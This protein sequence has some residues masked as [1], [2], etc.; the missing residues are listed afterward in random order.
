VV[1]HGA[2]KPVLATFVTAAPPPVS[3]THV[4]TYA[5]PESAIAA[6]AHV[7]R[8]AEWRRQPLEATVHFPDFDR[9]AARRVADDVLARGGGWLTPEETQSLLTAAGIPM[10]R[11]RTVS[12]IDDVVDAAR[13]IGLPVALKAVGPAIVHKSDVGGVR[14]ALATEAD[15]RAAALDM[16]ARLG[17]SLTGF[18]VQQMAPPGVEM[19]AGAIT[20]PQFGPVLSC[21]VGGVLV[22]IAA[23]MAFRLHPLSQRDARE[24][25]NEL[26]GARLL[27]GFRGAP[28]A[29]EPALDDVLL[30]LSELMEVCP[31]IQELDINPLRVLTIGAI[32]VDARV[33]IERGVATLSTRR[34]LY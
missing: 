8:Y 10:L 26:R 29:D 3:L 19:I 32:A 31:E 34:V 27:R 33:R 4:P 16:K 11:A 17:D 5:F 6:L 30:R 13:Q 22:E 20:D 12:M 23:D 15:L 24:M 18:L 28:P 7:T 2:T 21:G 14:L 1:T 25:I 9:A